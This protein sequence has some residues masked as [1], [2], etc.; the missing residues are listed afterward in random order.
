MDFV[1]IDVET[2]NPDLS[3]ICQVGIAS[4]RDNRL[5]DIWT[6]FINPEDYFEPINVSIHGIDE[7]RVKDAPTW[8]GVYP[9]VV[10]RLANRVIVS[11]TAF[12]RTAILRACDRTHLAFCGCRWLDSARVARRAWAGFARSGYGLS[13]VAE[14]L[15]IHYRAHDAGEDAQCAGE[16]LLRAIADTGLTLEQWLTRV[17]AS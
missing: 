1:A 8:A 2:A 15:G 16:V 9:D 4:F 11:H 10:S 17:S 14:Y 3:S 5:A 6:S 13:H 7:Y 12:D